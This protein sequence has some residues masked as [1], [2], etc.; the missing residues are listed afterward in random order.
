MPSDLALMPYTSMVF[1]STV[2]LGALLLWPWNWV[3]LKI[4]NSSPECIFTFDSLIVYTS[5][6][7]TK[8][9]LII[10]SKAVLILSCIIELHIFFNIILVQDEDGK[11]MDEE[12]IR[13]EVD[14][15]MFGGHDT[16]S[17]A[18]SWLMYNLARY[19]EYQQK[20]REEVQQLFA[21]KD[22]EC[23]KWWVLDSNYS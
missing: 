12:E 10:F 9:S 15:F 17:S 2:A 6:I 5:I 16:T 13:E 20:C 11:G 1:F 18:I 3:P 4:C 22:D 7:S 14:T 21:E 23:L 8:H 19:P